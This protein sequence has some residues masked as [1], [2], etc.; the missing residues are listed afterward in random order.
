MKYFF[1]VLLLISQFSL[2]A[3][4][5]PTF[6]FISMPVNQAANLIFND[7][8]KVPYI[9]SPE[10]VKDDRAVSFR[11][12]QKGL[13]PYL[14]SFFDQ[15]GYK[16]T[17]VSGLHLVQKRTEAVLP[18]EE[19]ILHVYR[20]KNRE[21]GYL[22]RLIAPV[23]K[24]GRFTQS[25]QIQAP[26]GAAMVKDVPATSAAGAIEQNADVLIF[27]GSQKEIDQLK[28][29]YAQIDLPSGEISVRAVIYE[30]SS[31]KADG[32]A[33]QLLTNLLG[34][35]IGI[36]SLFDASLGVAI[37]KGGIPTG[38]ALTIKFKGFEAVLSALST[39]NR[40]NVITQP[41]IRVKSGETAKLTVG[42]DVPVLG[43]VSY[44]NNNA[45]RSVDYRS[46]G[47]ILSIMPQ[48]KDDLIDLSIEQQLSN[49]VRTDTGVNESPTLIKRELKTAISAR[50]GDI[51]VLGGLTE[52]KKTNTKRGFSFLP[53]SL[54]K[55]DDESSTDV[56]VILQI[57]KI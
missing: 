24:T 2:A 4:P 29:L 16:Y 6:S 44:Q 19:S 50:S 7:A 12:P 9:L 25:K 54:A 46:A 8:L 21:S 39:D 53:F 56:I 10:V 15:L 26:V 32:S 48:I 30:V 34:T 23:F 37:D 57:E 49:F 31:S 27:S 14:A 42:Q 5:E 3:E 20:P 28:N 1:A 47:T 33:F 41:R 22:A 38:N 40:F 11:S 13:M 36:S 45:I 43:S 35:Q 51:V 18:A 17:V 52:T 55:T